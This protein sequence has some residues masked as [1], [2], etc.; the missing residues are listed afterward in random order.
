MQRVIVVSYPA[1][2]LVWERDLCTVELT[3]MLYLCKSVQEFVDNFKMEMN[4]VH[5]QDWHPHLTIMDIWHPGV[6]PLRVGYHIIMGLVEYKKE[7]Q[8]RERIM[9][10]VQWISVQV[11]SLHLMMCPLIWRQKWFNEWNLKYE[12]NFISFFF[13][14]E[15]EGGAGGKSSYV[16]SVNC[17]LGGVRDIGLIGLS[18]I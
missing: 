7:G 4:M 15:G 11:R 12:I 17:V 16:I 18:H 14:L 10:F 13:F 8:G 2:I 3:M 5:C 6:L 1:T 9:I